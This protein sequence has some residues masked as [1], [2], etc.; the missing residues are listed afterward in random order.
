MFRSIKQRL[1][2][3]SYVTKLSLVLLS[4]FGKKHY[5]TIDQVTQTMQRSG[6]TTV[7]L[8]FAHAL[9]CNRGDFKRHYDPLKVRCTYEG[10]RARASHLY[11]GGVR[12]FDAANII[13]AVRGLDI[14]CQFHESGTGF[15]T[16]PP[17]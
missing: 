9:F 15:F 8:A 1:A 6:F 12:D 3:K 5:Y 17:F 16:G 10:L 2:I 4:C 11:F 14:K 7:Y 13:E